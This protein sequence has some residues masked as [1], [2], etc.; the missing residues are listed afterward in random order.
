MD[1][2]MLPLEK[3]PPMKSYLH[4]AFP[5]SILMT[6]PYFT[7]WVLNHFIQMIY[8]P[9]STCP[10]DYHEPFYLDWPCLQA[11][12]LYPEMTERIPD[13]VEYIRCLL[14]EGWYCAAWVDCG[15]I[16]GTA[17][18]QKRFDTEG[19]LIYGDYPDSFEAMMYDKH[20]YSRA[21]SYEDFRR[22]VISEKFACLQF[23]KVNSLKNVDYSSLRIQKKLSCYLESE[24]YDVD[25]HKFHGQPE[26]K[27]YGVKA[28][29][30]IISYL[31]DSED[32][33]PDERWPVVFA[34]HKRLMMFRIDKMMESYALPGY[35]FTAED[36][37][38]LVKDAQRVLFLCMKH[39][40]SG[41]KD[42]SLLEEACRWVERVL[43]QERAMLEPIVAF[44]YV[45]LLTQLE[46]QK[47][48]K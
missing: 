15:V 12:V 6:N 42:R 29:R 25:D 10:Y 21:V 47:S 26:I 31:M 39:N 41:G 32:D 13:V 1:S 23:L 28:C 14:R 11:S 37:Q 35:P 43:E 33:F 20:Y 30:Q 16:P 45:G 24:N 40:M 7:D 38:R 34:E 48:Q 4:Y 5:L 3:N 19:L 17:L 27:A 46:A 9:N 36:R 18:Y 8:H 2:Y 44:D 22:S